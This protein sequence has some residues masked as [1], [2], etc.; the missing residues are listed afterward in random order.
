MTISRRDF[1]KASAA[2]AA[3]AAAGAPALNPLKLK[4]AEAAEAGIKW[5][6]APCRFAEPGVVCWW[7]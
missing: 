2:A 5:G 4:E 6:K 7:G 3:F 1:L